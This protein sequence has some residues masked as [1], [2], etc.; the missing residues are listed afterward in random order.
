MQT[1]PENV[2]PV[3]SKWPTPAPKLGTPRPVFTLMCVS[4]L[5]MYLVKSL[6]RDKGSG[7]YTMYLPFS[8]YRFLGAKGADTLCSCQTPCPGRGALP[9][10][11]AI[12]KHTSGVNTGLGVP[13]QRVYIQCF[14]CWG[15]ASLLT[16]GCLQSSFLA[17]SPLRPLL[18]ALSHCKQ[19]SF[20]C[21]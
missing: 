5:P 13:N 19:K 21:N 7:R 11:W 6:S 16:R 18:D 8:S 1:S 9:D 12:P 17:H 4:G 15:E 10:T 2:E 14:F 3:T 20:N